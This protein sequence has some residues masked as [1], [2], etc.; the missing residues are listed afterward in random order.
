MSKKLSVII[1]V[2]N[3][4]K[5]LRQCLDSVINQSLT[6]I[7]IICVDDGSTD[8]SAAILAEYS[9]RD[10]RMKV[11]NQPNSG[12]G[13]ARNNGLAAA[14]GEYI[15]FLDSD[16]WFEADYFEAAFRKIE[17]DNADICICGYESFDDKTGRML[18]SNWEK[19]KNIL[20][21]NSFS[22]GEY[23]NRIFQLTDGQVWDKLYRHSFIIQS[24]V[25]F[26]ELKAAEDTAFAYQTLIQAERITVLHRAFVHYRINRA[27]SVSK[28][29]A[30]SPNAPFD[31]FKLVYDFLNERGL[32]GKYEKSFMNW[33][34]E[35][36]VWQVNNAAAP[37]IQERYLKELR[38]RWFPE[39]RLNRYPFGY[40]ENRISYL[41]YLLAAYLP[42]RMYLLVLSHFKRRKKDGW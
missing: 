33:A 22:P 35:Y 25:R 29:F 4:E 12:A 40:F 37:L 1:P 36:L 18:A 5:Y 38:N 31:S 14:Q 28:S 10:G 16:D 42:E 32:L 7:E 34:M 13:A 3:C 19:K 20:P 6:D 27:G 24:D 11:I 17:A 15:L 26:P 39:L 23:S 41:K 21:E 2:Y 30:E 8:A 9:A